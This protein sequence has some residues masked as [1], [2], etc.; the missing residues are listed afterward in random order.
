MNRYFISLLMVFLAA[1]VLWAAEKPVEVKKTT[2]QDI[3]SDVVGHYPLKTIDAGPDR[4]GRLDLPKNWEFDFGMQR[5][6]MSHTS[7]EIG[8]PNAPFQKP[9]SRLE[10]PLNTWWL[11]F[12]LR[13]TCP[14]WSIGGRA[15]LRVATNTDGRMKDSD[16]EN[17]ANT[18]MLTTYSEGACNLD[19]GHHFR[20]D[21]DVNISDWLGLPKGFEVRPLCAFQFQRLILVD[22]DAVQWGVGNYDTETDDMGLDGAIS[23]MAL[24]GNTIRFR[25]DW[26]LYQIGLRGTYTHDLNKHLAVKVRGEA[27]WGPAVGFNEDQHLVRPGIMVGYIKSS[28][29]SLYFSTA[30]EMVIIKTIT[31]GIGMDYSFIRTTGETRHYNGPTGENSKWPDGVKAWSDQTGLNAYVSYAF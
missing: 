30:L 14:R 15:G 28:G 11:D 2:W 7:Y 27:D 12:R 3:V 20:G 4:A 25:Q 18:D 9:L 26:Y 13:R 21:V 24:P 8:N 23:A 29:N 16:W 31:L 19:E 6:V 1:S 5:F 10:F 22:H 17:P